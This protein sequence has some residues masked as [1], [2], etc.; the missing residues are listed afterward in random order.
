MVNSLQRG[1]N[2]GAVHVIKASSGE[3]VATLAGHDDMILT[4]D[5]APTLQPW[6]QEVGE[7][8]AFGTPNPGS[9]LSSLRDW[10]GWE[11]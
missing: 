5:F 6:R 2:L 4:L 10:A 7:R 3:I 1:T 11:Q 9:R 8:F